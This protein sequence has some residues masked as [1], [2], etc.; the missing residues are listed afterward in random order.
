MLKIGLDI[1]DGESAP[2]HAGLAAKFSA[3]SLRNYLEIYEP[4]E[5]REVFLAII[6]SLTTII[7]VASIDRI[8]KYSVFFPPPRLMNSSFRDF[9]EIDEEDVYI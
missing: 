3:W 5:E 1:R 9:H 7:G 6:I 4:R 2:L 8:G